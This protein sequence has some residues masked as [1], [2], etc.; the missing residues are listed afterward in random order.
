MTATEEAWLAAQEQVLR[1]LR[2]RA[3][4]MF[5]RVSLSDC[6]APLGQGHRG[7]ENPQLFKDRPADGT[8]SRRNDGEFAHL[9]VLDGYGCPIQ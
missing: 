9:N 2:G 1:M 4:C 6:F 7:F 3:V 5:A 8:A